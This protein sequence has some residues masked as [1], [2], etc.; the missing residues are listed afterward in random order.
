MSDDDEDLTLLPLVNLLS[1]EAF[2]TKRLTHRR[3][4]DDIRKYVWDRLGH[5]I[6]AQN[7]GPGSELKMVDMLN[8]LA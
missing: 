6:L 5:H 3:T 8:P 7:E 2:L 1:K 4:T